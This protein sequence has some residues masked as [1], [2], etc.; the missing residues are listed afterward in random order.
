MY[1]EKGVKRAVGENI[2]AKEV[3]LRQ[4]SRV[5]WLKEEDSNTRFSTKWLLSVKHSNSLRSH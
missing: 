3:C 1:K 5:K 2:D 4:K